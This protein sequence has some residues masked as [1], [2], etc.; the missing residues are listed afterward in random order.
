MAENP[1]SEEYGSLKRIKEE[2]GYSRS[3]LYSMESKGLIHF[4]R[5]G[6]KI[7]IRWEEIKKVLSESCKGCK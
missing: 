2:L 3:T 1:V 5:F 4:F 7:H 6:G